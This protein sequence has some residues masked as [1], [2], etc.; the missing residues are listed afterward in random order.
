MTKFSISKEPAVIPIFSN[1]RIH[2][3]EVIDTHEIT[4]QI[5]IYHICKFPHLKYINSIT[6]AYDDIIKNFTHYWIGVRNSLIIIFATPCYQTHM[7][8]I[9]EWWGFELFIVRQALSDHG[10]VAV[11]SACAI[12]QRVGV[13]EVKGFEGLVVNGNYS[14]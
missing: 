13:L 12:L 7:F 14:L 2:P 10:K 5:S 9:K 6:N 4:R 11:G 8:N 3:N 1:Y